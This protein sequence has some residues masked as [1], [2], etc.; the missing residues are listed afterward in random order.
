LPTPA[1]RAGE[2]SHLVPRPAVWIAVS[3][4]GIGIRPEDMGKLFQEFSQLDSSASRQQQGTGLGLALSR[5]FVELHAGTI[6]AESIFGKGST[7]WVILPVE[8]PKRRGPLR[9]GGT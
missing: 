2:Q 9:T 1:A 7:F 8:G 3:D 4:T 6:G 5:R